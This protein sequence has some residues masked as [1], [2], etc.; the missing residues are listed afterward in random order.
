MKKVKSNEAIK[1]ILKS[2]QMSKT[3]LGR[4]LGHSPQVIHNRLERKTME[5]SSIIEMAN[6]LDYKVVIMPKAS[7][8]PKGGYEITND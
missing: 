3:A 4:L 6:A 5:A 1:A 8:L 2:K 7:K